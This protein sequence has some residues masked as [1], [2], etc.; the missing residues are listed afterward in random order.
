MY[1]PY[2]FW[3]KH[4]EYL[5][6]KLRNTNGVISKLRFLVPKPTFMCIFNSLFDSHLR[7]ACQTL[8][9]NINPNSNRIFKLQKQCVRLLTF[10]DFNSHSSP[11]FFQLKILKLADLVKLLNILLI[12]KTLYGLSILL[13]KSLII[14]IILNIILKLIS[15]DRKQ[16]AYLI[17][18]PCCMSHTHSE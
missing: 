17:V 18:K 2:I 8:V 9:Q 14:P 3:N 12:Y 7:Y 10:S 16:R 15:Q 11:L 4:H 5:S 6:S 1:V 13:V